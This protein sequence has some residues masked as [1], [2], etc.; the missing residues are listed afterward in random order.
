LEARGE[1]LG[2]GVD[3]EVPLDVEPG[4]PVRLHQL[5][6]DGAST[7][8]GLFPGLSRLAQVADR[9]RTLQVPAGRELLELQIALEEGG[10]FTEVPVPASLEAGPVAL[11]QRVEV[12]DGRLYLVRE[13]SMAPAAIDPASWRRVRPA[14][15]S[16]AGHAEARLSFL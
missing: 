12:T 3:L 10:T 2:V 15:L 6:A 16:L 5:F 4:K 9:K 14:L 13:L 11:A 8:L 1:P 7:S